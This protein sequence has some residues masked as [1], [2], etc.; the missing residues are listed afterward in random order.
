MLKRNCDAVGTIVGECSRAMCSWLES[1]KSNR[2][3]HCPFQIIDFAAAVI[4]ASQFAS[5]QLGASGSTY[6]PAGEIRIFNARTDVQT[7]DP[8]SRGSAMNAL[9]SRDLR[10]DILV[11]PHNSAIHRKLTQSRIVT[12][13]NDSDC[14]D[15]EVINMEWSGGLSRSAMRNLEDLQLQIKG[16]STDFG[17]FSLTI[18]VALAQNAALKA[19]RSTREG[20]SKKDVIQESL[21]FEDKSELFKKI[22]SIKTSKAPD[23]NVKM[24][25]I[26]D[27]SCS[28]LTELTKSSTFLT[29]LPRTARIQVIGSLWRCQSVVFRCLFGSAV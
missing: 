4:A 28:K 22:T 18:A 20:A 14:L 5:R 24:L 6:A 23:S 2:S 25:S 3:S 15:K 26:E 13:K 10:S 16:S 1:L 9:Y 8:D 29:S 27:G 11:Y 21:S 17:S 7:K 19:L 12:V